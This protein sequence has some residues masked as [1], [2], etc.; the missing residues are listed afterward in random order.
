EEFDSEKCLAS[1]LS[2]VVAHEVGH[3]LGLRHNFKASTWRTMDEMSD[4]SL[5]AQTGVVGS[6]LDYNAIHISAPGQETG[7]YFT[8]AVGPY[9]VWAIQ[10]G[11][12]EFGSNEETAL[13]AIAA[14]SQDP[15]L[16]Y[17]TD[18]DLFMGDPY[19][20]TWDLGTD[21]VAFAKDQI[22]LAEAGFS[23]LAEKGAK[24]GEG[25]NEYTRFYGMFAGLYS[26]NLFG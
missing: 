15:G 25:Y 9:D 4:V 1:M 22:K 21:P 7:E 20:M 18:E 24:K 6:V 12:S 8:S 13:K 10:Y 19:A 2:E 17:G 26:R 14:R 23:K 3:T 11:Y 5:T 16:D